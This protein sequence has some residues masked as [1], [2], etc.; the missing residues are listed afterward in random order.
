MY[1]I[2][3]KKKGGDTMENAVNIGGTGNTVITRKSKYIITCLIDVILAGFT[4][5]YVLSGLGRH[6]SQFI[7]EVFQPLLCAFAFAI[8]FALSAWCVKDCD[9]LIKPFLTSVVLI[10]AEFGILLAS[11]STPFYE[12]DLYQ[13]HINVNPA[14]E[15][16]FNGIQ[17]AFFCSGFIFGGS[18]LI[19]TV[20]AFCYR[21]IR[22]KFS[23]G[24]TGSTESTEGTESYEK[25]KKTDIICLAAGLIV[26]CISTRCLITIYSWLFALGIAAMLISAAAIAHIG[27]SLLSREK[28]LLKLF[29][30]AAELI[31][32]GVLVGT[33]ASFTSD[34]TE[35]RLCGLIF[36]AWPL[37]YG[38][39]L[40]IVTAAMGIKRKV[41]DA[42]KARSRV[43]VQ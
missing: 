20:L 13:T 15:A 37:V 8:C 4:L 42:A 12:S 30:A 43:G 39:V 3:S 6:E 21:V 7:E 11:T 34:N 36:S 5:W 24:S 27:I 22:K 28:K 17:L 18:L 41:T 35:I 10:L 40:L 33:L 9:R 26:L 31:A 1:N 14:A 25:R 19:S 38:I 32:G 29:T 23:I 2:T 16:A